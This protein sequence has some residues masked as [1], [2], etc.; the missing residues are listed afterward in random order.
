[1]RTMALLRSNARDILAWLD[2]QGDVLVMGA[3]PRGDPD[4]ARVPILIQR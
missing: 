1:M 2:V 4:F 3:S